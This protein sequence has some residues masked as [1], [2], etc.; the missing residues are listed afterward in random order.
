MSHSSRVRDTIAEWQ[1]RLLQLDKRNNLLN[2]KPKRA[3]RILNRAADA[4]ARE[5]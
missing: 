3:V 1:T 5:R 2:F 4:F